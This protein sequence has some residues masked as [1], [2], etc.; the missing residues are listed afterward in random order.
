MNELTE[1]QQ[2]RI[3]ESPPRGTWALILLIGLGMLAAWLYFFF[4]V[5]LGHGPVN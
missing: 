2:R 5:F 3:L 1:E 4:G